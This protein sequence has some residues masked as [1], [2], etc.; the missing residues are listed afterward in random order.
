MVATCFIRM[1]PASVSGE[2]VS[3]GL[4][5][6]FGSLNIIHDNTSCFAGGIPQGGDII[7]FGEHRVYV[8]T[9]PEEYPREVLS[10]PDSSLAGNHV[11][12]GKAGLRTHAEVMIA[13]S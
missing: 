7:A 12:S 8:V 11:S 1:G 6:R 13:N 3:S 10:F 9:T 2:R 4:V 5:L